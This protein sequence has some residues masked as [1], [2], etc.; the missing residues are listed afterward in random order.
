MR[1]AKKK[2]DSH[3]DEENRFTAKK[4]VA[5]AHSEFEKMETKEGQKD[6]QRDYAEKIVQ[7]LFHL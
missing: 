1:L 7:Q 6:L 4:E 3:R 5:K 2:W